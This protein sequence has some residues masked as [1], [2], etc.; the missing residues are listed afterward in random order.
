VAEIRQRQLMFHDDRAARELLQSLRVLRTCI[1]RSSTQDREPF[2]HYLL[3]GHHAP[4]SLPAL[5]E[6]VTY[7]RR[8]NQ[9]GP[10]YRSDGDIL[11]AILLLS[12]WV[13]SIGRCCGKS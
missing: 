11:G 2:A 10:A 4:T 5:H 6:S 7:G 3:E 13:A 8:V 12:I 1:A 9:I